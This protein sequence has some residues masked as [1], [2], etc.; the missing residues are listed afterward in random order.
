M[1]IMR[2]N[3]KMKDKKRIENIRIRTAA[4]MIKEYYKEK[5]EKEEE[6]GCI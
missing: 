3:T 2:R 5:E 1:S 6:N 4:E